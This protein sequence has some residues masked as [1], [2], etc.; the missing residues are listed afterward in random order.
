MKNLQKK[1]PQDSRGQTR[2]KQREREREREAAAVEMEQNLKL[3]Q[4]AR[5]PH[6]RAKGGPVNGARRSLGHRVRGGP[7]ESSD[8][9]VIAHESARLCFYLP[10]RGSTATVCL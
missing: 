8:L 7:L 3:E 4:A 2:A 10:Q 6:S 5:R 9:F 1:T